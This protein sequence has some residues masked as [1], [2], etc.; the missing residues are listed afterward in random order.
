MKFCTFASGSSGNCSFLTHGDTRILI[1]AGIS[2]TRI[3]KDLAALDE[4]IEGLDGIFITHDHSDHIKALRMLFKYYDVPVYATWDTAAGIEFQLPEYR[5]RVKVISAGEVMDFGALRIL[6]FPTPHDAPGSVGYRFDA[7]GKSFGVL[8]DTGYVTKGIFD[9]MQGVDGILLEAN[10]NVEMLR[11]GP[12]PYYLR[13][14]ISSRKGHLSNE[15]CGEFAAELAASGTRLVIL[16]HLSD[17]N[18]TPEL[19]RSEVCR[20]IGETEMTVTVAPRCD[21]GR[22]YII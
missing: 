7:D 2:M 9:I 13:E 12:Y 5:G 10:H 1:D 11:N 15:Q 16:G 4:T 14:R 17:K 3:R 21:M 18:N 19:A 8:T 22:I 6:P 20:A